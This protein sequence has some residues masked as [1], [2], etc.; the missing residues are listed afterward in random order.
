VS[1]RDFPLV[2]ENE[3]PETCDSNLRDSCTTTTYNSVEPLY[4]YFGKLSSPE[5]TGN[6]NATAT[7]VVRSFLF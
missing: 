5:G 6:W 1:V 4:E 7:F 3:F 2:T